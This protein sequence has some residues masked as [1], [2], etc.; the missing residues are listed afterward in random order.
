MYYDSKIIHKEWITHDVLKLKLEK[1][2]TFQCKI[3]QAIELSIDIL[4]SFKHFAPFTLTNTNEDDFLEII[5]KVYTEKKRL[6]FWLSEMPLD[7]KIIISEAWDSYEYKG[8]GVFI[9]AGSG[10]TPFIPMIRNLSKANM[11]GNNTLIYANKK[12][13]DL[14]LRNELTGLLGDN[15]LNV[16]SREVTDS[17]LHGR[18][19]RPFL[20]SRI[21]NKRLFFY[22]CG[23]E[24]FNYS[25]KE[26]LISLGI[27]EEKIQVA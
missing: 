19:D 27:G 16:L 10:I 20:E 15:F 22:I 3:G 13:E 6:T 18:I 14:I 8:S 17:C 7:S 11:L 24:G 2:K 26:N 1:P 5:V 4:E 25:V 23:P 12:Q 9:A 21:G